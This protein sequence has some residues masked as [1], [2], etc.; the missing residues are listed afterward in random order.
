MIWAITSKYVYY[1][2]FCFLEFFKDATILRIWVNIKLV[3]G[4]ES[5]TQKAET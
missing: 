3:L 5:S 4:K 2:I 1:Q